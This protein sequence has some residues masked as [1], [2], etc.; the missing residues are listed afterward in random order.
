[1][2]I[3]IGCLELMNKK[4]E[5]NMCGLPDGVANS[6]ISDLKQRTERNIDKALEYAC[7]SWHKHLDNTTSDQKSK[8]TPVL[9]QFLE[10]KFL[11][12]LEVLSVLDATRD[13]I[14]ALEK[15]EKWLDVS[16][17]LL[18][19]IVQRLIGMDLGVMDS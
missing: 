18:F 12:W 17:I 1:M 3:L 15:A 4:L 9:C 10:K 16:C 19:V 13:A 7:R 2:E 11:F 6:E 14:D 8:I 5:Q